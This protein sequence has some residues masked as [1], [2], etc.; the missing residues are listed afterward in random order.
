VNVWLWS[1][2]VLTAALVP[3]G[4]LAATRPALEGLVA[5]EAA[6]GNAA[7]VMLLLSEGTHRQAFA[8]LALALVITSVAGAI[9][10]I[11]FLEATR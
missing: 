10:F 8:D 7:L 4:V 6:G 11:R 9:A 5:L 3:L 1:A 2:V